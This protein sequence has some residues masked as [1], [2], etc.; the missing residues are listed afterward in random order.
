MISIFGILGLLFV[1][2]IPGYLIT[3]VFFNEL[4]GMDAFVI[5]FG[6]SLVLVVLLSFL[7]TFFAW[8]LKRPLITYFN[9]WLSL[10]II[11]TALS[12]VWI[13]RHYLPN[14]SKKE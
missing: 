1:L 6:M 4:K 7:F 5:G 11:S 8:I 10:I 2:I 9:V 14:S 12:G 13:Y 3:I